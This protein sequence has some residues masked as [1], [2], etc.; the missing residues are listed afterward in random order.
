MNSFNVA[1]TVSA[2]VAV[3]SG[4]CG[5]LDATPQS[6]PADAAQAY[7]VQA[8][9]TQALQAT[10]GAWKVGGPLTGQPAM[11]P[12]FSADLHQSPLRISA[13]EGRMGVECEIAFRLGKDLAAGRTHDRAS[14]LQAV[15]AVLPVIE[16]VDARLNDFEDAPPLWKL[17]DNQ[18]NEGLLVGTQAA[19]EPAFWEDASIRMSVDGDVRKEAKGPNPGGDSLDLLVWLANH[20]GTHCAGLRAGQI[21]TTGSY[22]GLDMIAVGQTVEADYGPLGSLRLDVTA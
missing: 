15:D 5:R 6:A 8:G 4:Q 11:A 14:V 2:I 3:R 7:A 18:V 17:A 1:N 12:I 22:S 21:V 16:L 20:V 19:V 9:V 10:V 13:R